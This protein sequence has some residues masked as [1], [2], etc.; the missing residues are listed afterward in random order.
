MY[1]HVYRG[2]VGRS[3]QRGRQDQGHVHLLGSMGGIFLGSWAK[4][5]WSIQI[6]KSGVLESYKGIVAKEGTRRS[7]WMVEETVNHKDYWRRQ[8][9]NL[10]LLVTLRAVTEAMQLQEGLQAIWP[11]S[12]HAMPQQQWQEEV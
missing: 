6:K 12:M 5:G 7:L 8:I 1:T 4:S 10:H 2:H 11:N 9:R 3:R